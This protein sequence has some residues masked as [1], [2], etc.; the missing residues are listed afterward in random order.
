MSDIGSKR[1]LTKQ[2]VGF[3]EDGDTSKKLKLSS[4][5]ELLTSYDLRLFQK[6]VLVRNLKEYKL[7]YYALEKTIQLNQNVQDLKAYYEDLIHKINRL[8]S[9]VTQRIMGKT[10]S[11]EESIK[12][13]ETVEEI[14]KVEVKPIISNEGNSLKADIDTLAS[15]SELNDLKVKIE[16]LENQLKSVN[17]ELAIK[18][19]NIDI[20]NNEIT[21]K[22]ISIK[23]IDTLKV[24]LDTNKQQLE[25]IKADYNKLLN[26]LNTF[27][28]EKNSSSAEGQSTK[29]D[30]A[31]K[32]INDS[33]LIDLKNLQGNIAR[34]R[35]ERDTL[36]SDMN[37]L[38]SQE[39]SLNI[40]Q[41]I[42]TQVTS[43]KETIKTFEIKYA[44][45]PSDNVL[46][47]ELKS[48]EIAYN[49][50]AN[51]K[52]DDLNR[53]LIDKQK[54]NQVTFEFEKLK[55]KHV[56]ANRYIQ[57]LK[58]EIESLKK[59]KTKSD[60]VI[61]DYNI[62]DHVFKGKLANLEKRLELSS[63]LEKQQEL[64]EK[65]LINESELLKQQI[66]TF[67]KTLETKSNENINIKKDLDLSNKKLH[68]N[69][70]KIE[71]LEFQI[72]TQNEKHNNLIAKLKQTS[73]KLSNPGALNS[74]L[75]TT[76]NESTPDIGGNKLQ[77]QLTN[78]KQLVYC[79]LCTNN[80]K[81]QMIK[82]CG[83]TFCESCIQERLNARMRKCPSCNLPFGSTDVLDIVL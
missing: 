45:V 20:L 41:E 36:K 27:Q 77:D 69:S 30:E 15:E 55:E 58:M 35:S 3:I 24:E 1:S 29:F 8:N 21:N 31:L 83:H 42:N 78:F 76:V 38:K 25:F 51:T 80:F 66:D 12:P 14:P 44:S 6:D 46:L 39:S 7:K 52:L 81:D 2:D 63:M 82:N 9:P 71:D 48:I 10:V 16:V 61:A 79:P 75:G 60:E 37:I 17:S 59:L 72:A 47:E 32:S 11:A 43:I 53:A 73:E 54:H 65:I 28:N 62:R 70:K 74:L 34:I 22:D 23:T 40:I 64:D 19:N 49:E 5:D 33:L 18:S 67:K 50:L 57:D 56:S 68:E 13:E 4:P 26:K